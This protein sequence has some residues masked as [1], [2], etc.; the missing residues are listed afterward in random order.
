MKLSPW[1]IFAIFFALGVSALSYAWF[2]HWSPKTREAQMYRDYREALITEANKLPQ[3]KR[4]VEE[5]V[6]MVTEIGTKWQGIVATRTPAPTLA[7]GGI[8][9]AV[10]RWQLTVDA[11]KYRNSLQRAIN[12]QVRR[13]GVTVINGPTVPFPP[14][15]AQT[16]LE[17][18]FNFPAIA[19]PVVILDLGTVVV[20]GTKDQIFAN[21]E[22]WSRMPNYLAVADA[23]AITGTSPR[24]TGTYNVTVVGFIRGQDIAPPVPEVAPGQGGPGGAPGPGPAMPG[25]GGGI[26][27][28]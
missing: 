18:F 21:V 6:R 2:H 28:Q 13:G 22:A 27:A 3:A 11:R 14:D 9:L 15:S 7:Q 16:V 5:A 17:S 24:L 4:R 19:F 8:N 26:A 10:N 23:L 12:A 1:S 20:Q 25:G